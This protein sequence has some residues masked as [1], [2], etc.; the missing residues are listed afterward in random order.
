MGVAV[1]RGEREE[2]LE[3]MR[4]LAR[5]LSEG[6]KYV[7]RAPVADLVETLPRELIA[8]GDRAGLEQTL[9]RYRGSLYPTEVTIDPAACERVMQAHL[10]A[11]IQKQAVDME[12]LLDLSVVEG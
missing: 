7:Q 4:A 5:A 6:L 1:R 2:R 11:G 8:G 10:K 12:A 3:E 9:A